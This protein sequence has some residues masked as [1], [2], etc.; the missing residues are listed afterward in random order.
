M[1]S[2]T[3]YILFIPILGGLLLGLNLLLA[4]HNPYQEKKTSFECGFS[5]FL[6]QNRTQF[7]ISFFIFGILFLLFDL[8]ILLAYPY[9]LSSYNNNVYGL[10]I[11][12]IFFVILTV[13][14]AVELGKGALKINSRQVTTK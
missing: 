9:A 11:I 3:L 4:P 10:I 1:T 12:L 8:E 5:S 7:H 14:F 6:G 2:L 13:G